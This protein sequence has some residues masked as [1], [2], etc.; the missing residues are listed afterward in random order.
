MKGLMKKKL[1]IL[2][3]GPSQLPAIK[4]AVELGFY[5]I[6]VDYFPGNLGH[7]Y[8]HQYVNCSTVNQ[9]GILKVARELN[10][11]GIMTFAS[12]VSTPTV[13]YVAEHLGVPGGP[14]LVAETMS[15]KAKF[16]MFQQDQG[17][18]SPG[19]V[20]GQCLKNIQ[21]EIEALSPPLMFKPV[22]TSGSRG[23]SSV[24]DKNYNTLSMAFDHAQSFSRSKLVCVE[25]FVPGTD[26]SGDGFLVDGQL[27]AVI[28]R[29]YKRGFVPIG[30]SVPTNISE[31]K[32]ARVLAEVSATCR[33]LGY[34]DGPLDFDVRVSSERTV[35]L[36]MS[37]RLGGN[38]IP[39][40]ITRATDVDLIGATL[41]FALGHSVAL[42]PE[43][44]FVR[45]CASWVFGSNH[46][47]RLEAIASEADL[48]ATVPEVFE[49]V[50]HYKTGEEIPQF[51]H[52]GNSLGYVLFDFP[53]GSSYQ[54]MV[55]RIWSALRFNVPNLAVTL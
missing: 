26:V 16:R 30:H 4:K 15:N 38:G 40:L 51:V 3:A 5:V 7:R 23:I 52:S 6:T 55:D 33:K 12:D 18:D 19:F 45:S 50:V 34:T 41:F 54:A 2:G 39:M 13:S 8:S 46:T 32:Q 53:L 22:D 44:E 17:L 35:I 25:E 36:E 37:P 14:A 9:E 27:F 43:P 20:V 48:R 31:E 11:D 49:Y 21:D 10:I 47:G 28:T 24:G 42:P 29:K 1:M